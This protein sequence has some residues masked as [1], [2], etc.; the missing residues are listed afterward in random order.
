M[1]DLSVETYLRGRMPVLDGIRGLAILSVLVAHTY[2]ARLDVHEVVVWIYSFGWI[3]VDLFFVLSGFLITGILYDKRKDESYY[4]TFYGRRFLRIFPLY[5]L[6]LVFVFFV[7]PQLSFL[8]HQ[9]KLIFEGTSVDSLWYWLYIQN[10]GGFLGYPLKQEFL[11]ITWS[12]AIE[13]QFYFLWP[14][15][16]RSFD[17]HRLLWI[18][19][20]ILVVC[21]TIRIV[22]FNFDVDRFAIY[23]FTF[24][25]FDSIVA[26]AIIA[27][28]LRDVRSRDITVKLAPV[29]FL[30]G[31]VITLIVALYQG[32]GAATK[33]PMQLF[34]YPA[35]ALMLAGFLVLSIKS[36]LREGVLSKI[37]GNPLLRLMGLLCYGL[38]I[39]HTMI[40]AP[41]RPVFIEKAGLFI[42]DQTLLQLFFT[43]LMMPLCIFVAWLSWCLFEEKIL[44]LKRLFA[45]SS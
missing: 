4:S 2:A 10:I 21:N 28:L 25:R 3:G 31:L 23:T 44:K 20:F 13:E 22:C 39:T 45:Y 19:F 17:R 26:G 41:L 27:L 11:S 42:K 40:I 7:I 18:C 16:I 35:I 14:L 5:Y 37:I 38:Y 32:S 43:L 6:L 36:D 12:L 8:P 30:S 9:D 1:S 33:V 15:L 24:T 34:G 29:C